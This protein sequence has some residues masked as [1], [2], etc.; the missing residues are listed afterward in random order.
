MTDATSPANGNIKNSQSQLAASPDQQDTSGYGDQAQAQTPVASDSGGASAWRGRPGA[1]SPA[2]WFPS[3]FGEAAPPKAPD[4]EPARPDAGYTA[5]RGSDSLGSAVLPGPDFFLMCHPG[6][7]SGSAARSRG[8]E[9]GQQIA[10]EQPSQEPAQSAFH[11]AEPPPAASRAQVPGPTAAVRGRA[12]GPGFEVPPQTAQR[13]SDSAPGSVWQAAHEVW[14]D[15]GVVWEPSP[16]DYQ[17]APWNEYA[18]GAS[19]AFPRL[20]DDPDQYPQGPSFPPGQPFPS[21]EPFPPFP[22]ATTRP[23][24][25]AATA[26]DPVTPP[27]PFGLSLFTRQEPTAGSPQSASAAPTGP[28]QDYASVPL[29]ELFAGPP[30]TDRSAAPAGRAWSPPPRPPAADDLFRAW[31]SSV[32]PATGGRTKTGRRRRVLRTVVPAVVVV[33]VGVG[34]VIMLTGKHSPAPAS[35]AAHSTLASAARTRTSTRRHP[36]VKRA[37]AAGTRTVFAG[38][39][40]QRGTVTVTAMALGHGTRLAVGSA[41]GHPA[42]WRRAGNDWIL[43]TSPAVYRRPGAEGLTSI[44]Y[45][46][47]GW[48]AVGGVVSGAAQQPVVVTSANGVTWRAVDGLAAFA[49]RDNY[50]TGVSAGHGGYVVV[51]RHAAGR[52]T[53]AAMW[54]SANL[55]N[56]A[57]GAN[58]GL[59][60]GLAPSSVYAVAAVPAG[61]VAVGTHGAS[62]SIWTSAD[63]RHWQVHDIRPPAGAS[64]ATLSFVA[65]DG[66]RVVAAGYA[67]TKEGRIPIVVVS[68]DGGRQ[69]QQLV[70][71][72]HGRLGTVTALTAAG[73][74]FVAAGEAGPAH[75][76]RTVT[77][78]SPNGLKWAAAASANVGSRPIT[79]LT[80]VGN[81]VTG[82]AQQGPVPAIVSLR[83]H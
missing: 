40:G 25:D 65:V 29:S 62:S 20:A 37:P 48:I 59:N 12:G 46:P 15:S 44:A 74:G 22:P 73:G 81:G 38:Y 43:D 56:W 78:S 75:A 27:P 24:D 82:I 34:A 72:A 17:E 36:A 53:F 83:A 16:P 49:G 57:T 8:P 61:F 55:R 32:R 54:W 52:R 64:S 45:G 2:G 11:S 7:R 1:A 68:A 6:P 31:Q 77:W 33:A 30:E 47:A 70:L 28:P 63:G 42:I 71:A 50:V 41:D 58:G 4:T 9:S 23:P 35:G 13:H 51:G 10:R 60:G 69:W 18:P 67:D 3:A 21:S 66:G 5:F 79:V 19:A 80:A 26:S 76:Q 39:R 14:Q